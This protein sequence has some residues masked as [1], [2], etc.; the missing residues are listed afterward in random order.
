MTE[1]IPD[2]EPLEEA[3]SPLEPV[4]APP[5]QADYQQMLFQRSLQGAP[6]PAFSAITGHPTL[7][8]GGSVNSLS[9]PADRCPS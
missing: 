8:H 4:G 2:L 3:P 5:P 6:A 7:S 1:E 9:R